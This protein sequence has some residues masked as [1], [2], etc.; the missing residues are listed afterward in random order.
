M[1]EN[2]WELKSDVRNER[3]AFDAKKAENNLCAGV[4][5][6]EFEKMSKVIYRL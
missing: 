3:S 6:I 1:R 4:A 5:T 2:K